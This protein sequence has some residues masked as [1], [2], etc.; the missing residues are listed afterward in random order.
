MLAEIERAL[1]AE[2]PKFAA[3]VRTTTLHSRYQRRIAAA[4]AV[5]VVGLVLLP[6]ALAVHIVPLGVLGFVLMLTGALWGIS[7][8]KRMRSGV[9]PQVG[10]RRGR[11]RA[12]DGHPGGGRN[13]GPSRSKR[14]KGKGGSGGFGQRFHDRWERRWDGRWTDEG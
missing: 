12:V 13:A 8:L 3:S 4:I 7:N 11:L 6:V 1:Y 2:D 5:V 14:G 9:V 10:S